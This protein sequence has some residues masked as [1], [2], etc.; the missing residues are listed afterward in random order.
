MAGAGVGEGGDPQAVGRVLRECRE[1]FGRS[2]DEV[3]EATRIRRSYLEGLEAGEYAAFPGDFWARL[4]L[5]SYAQHLGLD[6]DETVARAFGTS[7]D[8]AQPERSPRTPLELDDEG[9]PAP[10][11]GGPGYTPRV[12]PRARADAGRRETRARRARGSVERLE[13]RGSR[14]S[15]RGWVSPL[16]GVLAALVVTALLV[17][18]VYNFVHGPA[19]PPS[20][21]G[22][23]SSHATTA[24]AGRTKAGHTSTTRSSKAASGFVTVSIDASAGHATYRVT[25]TPI[26]VELKFAGRCWIGIQAVGSSRYLVDQ[27]FTTGQSLHYATAQPVVVTVGATALAR[28]SLNGEAF[29]PWP[30]GRPWQLTLE[31]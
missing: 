12:R 3:A 1:A 8:T 5:R 28:G 23:S 13:V 29:G 30:T 27:T 22:G 6:A 21:V 24:A 9:G 11:G 15:R 31:P 10:S 19:A 25:R 20:S 4:F 18:I 2:L 17:A 16:F 26:V 7:V 14:A